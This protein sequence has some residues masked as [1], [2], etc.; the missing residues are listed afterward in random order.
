MFGYAGELLHLA[1]TPHHQRKHGKIKWFG[2]KVNCPQS[3]RFDCDV[4]TSL[5]GHHH[6]AGAGR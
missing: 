3:H 4:D 5:R 1:C 2:K 6:H